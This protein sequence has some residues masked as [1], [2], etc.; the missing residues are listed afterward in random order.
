MKN[1][2]VVCVTWGVGAVD[3]TK[4]RGEL[5][6]GYLSKYEQSN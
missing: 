6:K 1:K 3:N 5:L 2:K 4:A